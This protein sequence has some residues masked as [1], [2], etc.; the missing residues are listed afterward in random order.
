MIDKV[1]GERSFHVDS[2]NLVDFQ[3]PLSLLIICSAIAL[4]LAFMVKETYC[5]N[6]TES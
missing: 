2:L 5:K 4:I 1:A 3:Q 6:I